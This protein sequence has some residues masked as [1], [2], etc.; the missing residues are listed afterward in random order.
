MFHED[1]EWP[2][3]KFVGWNSFAVVLRI[4]VLLVLEVLVL[5]R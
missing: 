2:A 5:G 3:G 1:I 4:G